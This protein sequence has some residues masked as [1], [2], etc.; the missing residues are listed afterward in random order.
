M[1][2]DNTCETK[3]L[4]DGEATP[5]AIS[6]FGHLDCTHASPDRTSVELEF[7]DGGFGDAD[8]VENSII[9]DPSGAG[10]LSSGSGGGGGGGGCLISTAA[11]GLRMPKESLA[12]VFLAGLL[13]ISLSVF[14]KNFKK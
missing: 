3:P 14:R 5:V 9:I 4:G 13:M 8:G 7:K 6:H 2:V 1:S 10:M 11:Y 12:L